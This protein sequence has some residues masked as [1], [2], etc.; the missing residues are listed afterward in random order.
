M[1]DR[2]FKPDSGTELVF[3]DSGSTDRLRIT[4]GGSTILYD[5]GGSVALTIDTDGDI[6]IANNIVAGTI[7]ASVVFP[8]GGTGNPISVAVI[9]DQ[10]SDTTD[11]GGT[12][13]GSFQT[14]DLNTE[15]SD[16]DGIVSI[17]SNQFTL[18][19]GT[20]HIYFQAPNFRGNA[21]KAMLFD[22]TGAANLG[23][24]TNGHS[25]S[26]DSV[27]NIVS[28]SFVHSPASSN[29]YEIQH[30][31]ETTQATYG[32]GVACGFSVVETYTL[33]IISKLK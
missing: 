5:H 31:C 23:F 29:T 7:G 11:G 21:H 9:C 15:I 32:F 25:G 2:N 19:A 6:Q 33:V 8:A 4:D 22:V 13:S 27:A 24:S 26:G 18:G 3:E 30:R 28:G 17:S 16:P 12:T 20:Y 1:T 14:R 10:K